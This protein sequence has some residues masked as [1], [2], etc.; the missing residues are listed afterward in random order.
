MGTRES[1][2]IFN[3]D[4]KVSVKFTLSFRIL[5]NHIY[6]S[7]GLQDR[8]ISDKKINLP[9]IFQLVIR[10][11]LHLQTPIF[12]WRKLKKICYWNFD[13]KYFYTYFSWAL[14]FYLRVCVN[15]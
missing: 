2:T 12:S 6:F 14:E 13:P 4:V 10:L 11:N 7:K 8:K 15:N 5:Y 9:N 1:L 3:G